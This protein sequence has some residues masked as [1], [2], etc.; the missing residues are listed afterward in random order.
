MLKKL[1]YRETWQHVLDVMLLLQTLQCVLVWF[2]FECLLPDGLL[3][4]V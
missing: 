1:I 4:Y 3:I 2:I